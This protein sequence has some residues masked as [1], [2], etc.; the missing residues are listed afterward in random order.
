MNFKDY[1]IVAFLGGRGKG[2][3]ASG[4][5]LAELYFLEGR[6]VYGNIWISFGIKIKTDEL[7]DIERFKGSCVLLDEPQRFFDSRSWKKEGNIEIGN[8]LNLIR[9][10]DIK[11]ILC[12]Q[13]MNL[14]ELRIRQQIDLIGFPKIH[15][16]LCV[17]LFFDIDK[18]E[19]KEKG[20][21][22]RWGF[23]MN[24]IFQKYNTK[25]VAE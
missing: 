14:I 22:G 8:F 25:E 18:I 9:K 15:S 20:Q 21:K 13:Y 19:N 24:E 6:K 1:G 11:L 4:V 7:K 3:T 10:F 16:N 2:K 12:T 17:V 23:D 5:K